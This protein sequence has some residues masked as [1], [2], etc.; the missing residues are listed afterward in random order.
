[1]MDDDYIWS[2]SALE[3]H[4]SS[5]H[6]DVQSWAVSAL[7]RQYPASRKA[8][9][10]RWLDGS[11][12]SAA[13]TVLVHLLE[14]SDPDPALNEHLRALFL[15]GEPEVSALAIRVAGAWKVPEAASWIQEKILSDRSLTPDQIAA[16]IGTLGV[17]RGETAY[18]LLKATEGS[19]AEKR[20]SLWM[21]YYDALLSHGKREDID[22]L[23][24]LFTDLSQDESRR[25]N[26]MQILAHRADPVLN[27][28]DLIFVHVEGVQKHLSTRMDLLLKAFGN[29]V[30]RPPTDEVLRELRPYV[31]VF[32]PENV[33]MAIEHLRTALDALEASSSFYR[34]LILS[35]LE[36]QKRCKVGSDE[37]YG[38][39]GLGLC[40]LI[41]GC[42]ER[43]FPTPFLHAP[44]EERR[45]FV[46]TEHFLRPVEPVL[47]ESVVRDAPGPDFKAELIETL[48]KEPFSWKTFQAVELMGRMGDA[49]GAAAVVQSVRRFK[50]SSFL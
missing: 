50:Y 41:T 21:T 14:A 49:D 13:R 40:S 27:P 7:L 42:I 19:M 39:A 23:V 32:R 37:S 4:A 20:G 38:L 29:R 12:P 48:Q 26:S 9:V 46:L 28:S 15:S 44:W 25:R 11:D 16:M 24:N 18:D 30:P 8:R 5:V 35:T 2:E 43:E 10:R 1:M 36:G 33:S 17:T 6:P 47:L 3:R 31:D 34:D 22:T 45:A